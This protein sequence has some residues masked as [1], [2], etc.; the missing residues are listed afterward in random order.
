MESDKIKTVKSKTGRIWMAEDMPGYHSFDEIP[1]PPE[2]FR[3]P[4]EEEWE[5]EIETWDSQD[6]KGAVNS[7]LKLNPAGNRYHSNGSLYYVGS[8]GNYW[9][10]TVNGS[11][12]RYLYFSSDY[13]YMSNSNRAFGQSVR[14]IKDKEIKRAKTQGAKGYYKKV[15]RL[16][17]TGASAEEI[18]ALYDKGLLE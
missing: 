13:A 17:D 18:I 10:S 1:E 14:F 7:L 5:E 9:S 15:I 11:N 8:V 16:L 4:T 6:L 12:A 2:G 3:L